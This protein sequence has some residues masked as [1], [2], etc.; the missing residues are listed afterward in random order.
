MNT[1]FT[2]D[3]HFNHEVLRLKYACRSVYPSKEE[4]TD[5]IV[6]NWN[7]VIRPK[8]IVYHLGDFGGRKHKEDVKVLSRLNGRIH[9]LCGN[10]DNKISKLPEFR[11]GLTELWTVPY[12]EI[13]IDG[14]FIIMSHYPIFDWNG[15]HYGSWHLHGHLHG[16]N[17][18]IPGKIL[19]VGVDANDL[20]PWH[21]D[22]VKSYMDSKEKRIPWE[23]K[24]VGDL[25]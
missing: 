8:D 12:K 19:D 14:G 10:H 11:K 23:E 17:H 4:M 18:G 15:M 13:K 7:S 24:P 1:W 9:Y 3:T 16:R 21:Y 25:R 22:V 5:G 2:S 6:K 20:M